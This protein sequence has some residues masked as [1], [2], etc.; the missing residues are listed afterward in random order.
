LWETFV[1]LIH[2]ASFPETFVLQFA[3]KWV[4]EHAHCDVRNAPHLR[5]DP[6]DVEAAA[7]WLGNCMT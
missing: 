3:R 2:R 4:N 5:M 1:A 7:K 6:E